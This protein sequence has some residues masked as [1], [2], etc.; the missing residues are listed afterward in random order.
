MCCNDVTFMTALDEAVS[1]KVEAKYETNYFLLLT[2][3]EYTVAQ[4]GCIEEIFMYLLSIRYLDRTITDLKQKEELPSFRL[5][6][7][8]AVPHDHIGGFMLSS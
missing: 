3:S 7:R 8:I 2:S 6:L 4:N 1:N 5:H